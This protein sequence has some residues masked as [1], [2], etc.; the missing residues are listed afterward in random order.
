MFV[1]PGLGASTWPLTVVLIVEGG[2][3]RRKARSEYGGVREHVH[4]RRKTQPTH[5]V[6]AVFGGLLGLLWCSRKTHTSR[7]AYR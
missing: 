1:T 6:Y 5:E 3:L 2:D 7:I 4:K